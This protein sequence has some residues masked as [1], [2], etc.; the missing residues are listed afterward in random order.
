MIKLLKNKVD[1]SEEEMEIAEDESKY[2]LYQWSLDGDRLHH[3]PQ[4][5]VNMNCHNSALI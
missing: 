4:R 3:K 2:Y 1:D 5:A